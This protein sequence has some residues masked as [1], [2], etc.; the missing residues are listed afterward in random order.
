MAALTP[1]RRGRVRKSAQEMLVLCDLRKTPRPRNRGKYQ[2][3]PQRSRG[4]ATQPEGTPALLP[5]FKALQGA[6]DL[7]RQHDVRHIRNW[8]AEK[9]ASE[10][11]ELLRR[12]GDEEL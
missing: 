3:L 1:E 11:L 12:V 8:L 9:A 4:F 7:L 6:L 2:S 10:R 5:G